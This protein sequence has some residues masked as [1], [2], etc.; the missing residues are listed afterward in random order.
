MIRVE[1][2]EEGKKKK[3]IEINK[4]KLKPLLHGLKYIYLE[5]NEE[6]SVVISTKLTKE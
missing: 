1:T 4:T 3:E 5:N 2:N 6:K